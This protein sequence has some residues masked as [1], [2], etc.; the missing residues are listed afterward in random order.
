MRLIKVGV[1]YPQDDPFHA[2]FET[3]AYASHTGPEMI[4]FR[5]R[6]ETD[7]I[8]G[9]V[10]VAFSRDHGDT[11][12]DEQTWPSGE[13]REA[14]VYRQYWGL[15]VAV[16]N[17]LLL[18]GA[19][20]VF[21]RD[22]ALDGMTQY[23]PRYRVSADGGRT[24]N[25][26]EPIVQTGRDL[27]ASHPFPNVWL[28]RNAVM[29]ANPPL[30]LRD[31]RVLVPCNV[32]VLGEDG[33]YVCPPG[34]YTYTAAGILEGRWQGD[35]RLEW[36]MREPVRIKPEQSLRGVI[37]PTLAEMPDG[38]I[39]M[40]LRANAGSADPQSGWKWF[41]TSGDKGK[42]WS[43]PWPW[44]FS[45]GTPFYSP[46]SISQLFRHS[47]G[48]WY[49]IGNICPDP[50]QGNGPRHPLVIGRVDPVTLRL[51][52][53]SLGVIDTV[54]DGDTEGLQLSNFTLVEDRRTG[55]VILRLTRLDG[56]GASGGTEPIRASVVA[57]TL[58]L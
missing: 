11:W 55:D 28:G 35:G 6:E 32:T 41:C 26:D 37:E 5:W 10:T 49:W 2:V 27:D 33:A 9:A 56:G 16:G 15:P 13:K 40:V 25:V 51:D 3:V 8:F 31:G 43:R 36:T 1:T 21:R 22:H 19:D 46:S 4:R 24:W 53:E 14:G 12:C 7:D 23:A 34:A 44:T 57:Y 42:T 17:R 38:R 29:P 45:D 52:G 54:R 30:V 48:E 39:L 58:D 20:G 18:V 47:S 50:P